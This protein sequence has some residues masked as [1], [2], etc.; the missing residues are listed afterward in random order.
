MSDSLKYEFDLNGW[1][2]LPAL[3]TEEQLKP[4]RAHQ[5]KLKYDRESLP[6]AL[7]D[8]H[9]GP[10]Q[11]MLD[12][13]VVVGVLN[14]ILSNQSL[15]SEDCYGFRMD[16]TGVRA[17]SVT[18]PCALTESI[19]TLGGP[20]AVSPLDAREG[21]KCMGSPRRRRFLQLPRQLSHVRTN[22]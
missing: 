8:T 4:I 5:L 21:W 13:P 17:L 1:I 2:L 15:A 3:L 14:E 12:H 10:S 19:S 9:A 20:C 16:H 6:P 11:V 18:P 7:R 22:P